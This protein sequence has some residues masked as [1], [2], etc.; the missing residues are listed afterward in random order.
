MWGRVLIHCQLPIVSNF[1]MAK[2]IHVAITAL[3]LKIAI[4]LA[5][6]LVDVFGY[7]DL[8]AAEANSPELFDPVLVHISFSPN[9]HG[10]RFITF[11]EG[12]RSSDGVGSQTRT[13]RT[14]AA[15]PSNRSFLTGCPDRN[16]RGSS[17]MLHGS[18]G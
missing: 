1:V 8:P 5:V 18:T 13:R 11:V 16:S 15:Y 14:R 17:A 4:V 9:L 6:P 7:F 12:C 3:H 2:N 10:V